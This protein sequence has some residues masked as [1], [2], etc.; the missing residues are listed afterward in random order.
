MWRDM[1][2]QLGSRFL[3]LDRLGLEE[4]HWDMGIEFLGMKSVDLDMT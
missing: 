4:C 3:E 1:P 2:I